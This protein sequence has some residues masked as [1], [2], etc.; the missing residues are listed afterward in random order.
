VQNSPTVLIIA[1][2]TSFARDLSG[3]W[4]M[5]RNA[6]AITVVTTELFHAVAEVECDVVIVGPVRQGRL[7]NLLNRVD[8]GK[9]S[10]IC[11]LE[12]AQETHAIRNQYPRTLC[13]QKHES[14]TESMVL[15]AHECLK[16]IALAARLKKAEQSAATTASQAAL[17]RYM[18]EAR[19][20]FNNSLTSVL[21]NAE[22]LMMD[23]AGLPDHARD[24]VE[25]I[26][27]M[28]LHLHAVM[29]RFSSIAM[30]MQAVEK[31]SQDETERASHASFVSS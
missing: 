17:G 5:E 1:D 2:D 26:H 18:L 12:T 14:W 10:V 28:S 6:P 15:L 11:V 4:Q 3:R 21:G 23:C 20:D 7:P 31:Q 29:Q 19:H 25:T 13:L 9:H 30:E 16:R 8:S 27:E 24:Q 22:L